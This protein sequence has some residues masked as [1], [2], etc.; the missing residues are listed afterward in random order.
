MAAENILV[1]VS[2]VM[3]SL[4]ILFYY[5]LFFAKGFTSHTRKLLSIIVIFLVI[6]VF[7]F[8]TDA[9]HLVTI[10]VLGILP[11]VDFFCCRNRIYNLFMIIPACLFYTLTAVFPMFMIP[12]ITRNDFDELY[13]ISSLTLPGFIADLSLTLLLIGTYILCRRKKIDLR[14][15]FL[16]VTGVFCFFYLRPVYA[17]EHGG[18]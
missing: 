2:N 12:L 17:A 16:E 4:I 3:A 14:L 1:S 11:A 7:V 8:I 9:D 10:T 18:I 5:L 15:K 13:G 6:H